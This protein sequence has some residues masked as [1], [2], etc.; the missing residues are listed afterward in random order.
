MN[1]KKKK[2]LLTPIIFALG[3]IPLLVHSFTYRNGLSAF[4]WFPDS[5][6]VQTDFFLVYKMFAIIAVVIIMC[7]LLAYQY[8]KNKNEC[9]WSNSWCLIIV[10]AFMVFFSGLFSPY[11][12]FAFKGCYEVFETVWVVLGYAIMCFYAYQMI[13]DE[14]DVRFVAKYSLIG[15]LIITLIG[16]FQYFGFDIFRTELGKK[17]IT[18]SAYWDTLDQM[19]FTFPLHTSYTTLYN[20]NYL[21]FYFGLL[22]PILFILLLFTKDKKQ[23][24]LYGVLLLISLIT[25]IGSNSKSALLALGIT[26]ALGCIV[27]YRYLKKY[28]WIPV[29]T[30]AG[31]IFVIFLYADHVGGISNLWSI[32]VTGVENHEDQYAIKDIDTLGNEIVI[33]TE[34]QNIHVEYSVIDADNALI[35]ITDDN[36]MEIP[37]HQEDM[38]W[39]LDGE[40]YAGCKIT[41][42]YVEDYI[43]IQVSMDGH[44]WY[45]TNQIDGTYY[46]YNGVGKFVKIPDIEK[47]AFFPDNIISGRGTLW[48]YTLP[49]LKSCILFGKGSNTFAM[50]YP[51]DNYIL[52]TYAGTSQLFD[53]KAHSFYFQQFLENGLI[54]LL[55]LLA[56]Y[57]IYF[58]DSFIIY[59]K[60]KEYNFSAMVG[61]GI[62]LGTF[63]YMIIAVAN[64]SNVNTAP[65]FWILLGAGVS[66]NHMLKQQSKY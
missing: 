26:F 10:Y 45:F 62:M 43:G 53:V 40:E 34:D 13:L 22:I 48:N 20:T 61:L 35:F 14:S 56:F 50:V 46:Y 52:K 41:P 2:W 21:A 65:V 18:R 4:D 51:N 66:I 30:L 47:S 36:G 32:I 28:F 7:V 16:F 63:N 44:D 57:I 31:F 54:A 5:A 42:V 11:R 1:P 27:L 9:K 3:F 29:A 24:I 58:V 33:K 15:F 12:S 17:I 25:L 64:D 23:K 49:K 38:S 55:A 37:K 59:C 6:D 8:M 60:L 19:S 39:V